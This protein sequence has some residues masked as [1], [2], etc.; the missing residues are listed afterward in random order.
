MLFPRLWIVTLGIF[1][2]RP[3]DVAFHLRNLWIGF[4]DVPTAVHTNVICVKLAA[5]QA[6]S[7]CF[8]SIVI[9]PRC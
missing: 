7:L 6:V 8:R 3:N 1:Q 9:V 2:V 5:M 4:E